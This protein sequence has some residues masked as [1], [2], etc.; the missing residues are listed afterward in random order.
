MSFPRV[1][2]TVGGSPGRIRIESYHQQFVGSVTPAAAFST[3]NVVFASANAPTVR[4]VSVDGEAV[5]ANPTGSFVL[6]D[7]TISD[8]G[9]V[10]IAIEA[11]NI[12]LGTAVSLKLVPET[13]APVTAFSDAL[14]GTFESSTATASATVPAGFSRFYVQAS[15]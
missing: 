8:G 2:G 5:P 15:W 1:A 13:G 4:V 6:P 12:P 11:H 14:A 10:V 7:V 9:P 3:P